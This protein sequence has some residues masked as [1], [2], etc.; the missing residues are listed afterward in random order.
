MGWSRFCL[1]R[2]NDNNT[3]YP[4]PLLLRSRNNWIHIPSK[5]WVHRETTDFAAADN[6][7]PIRLVATRTPSD[8]SSRHERLTRCYYEYTQWLTA[9]FC[10]RRRPRQTAGSPSSRVVH[11]SST[12]WVP[13][14]AGH[15]FDI[16]SGPM[17]CLPLKQSSWKADDMFSQLPSVREQVN[18]HQLILY[19][20]RTHKLF[21][22]GS[23]ARPSL[24]RVSLAGCSRE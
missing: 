8:S 6:I 12:N 4:L 5:A 23:L 24:H 15:A 1:N 21:V 3:W 22:R 20:T 7:F 19:S 18:V 16:F 11:S 17:C 13:S 2:A 10:N 14:G 9:S